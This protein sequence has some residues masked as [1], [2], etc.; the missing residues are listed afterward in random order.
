MTQKA[1]MSIPIQQEPLL[2]RK[3][4]IYH[5]MLDRTLQILKGHRR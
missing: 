5:L 1:K 4:V 3:I 2:Q